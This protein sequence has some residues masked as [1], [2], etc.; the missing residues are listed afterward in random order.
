MEILSVARKCSKYY[1]AL[2]SLGCGCNGI[3]H[4]QSW[5]DVSWL[6]AMIVSGVVVWS[7][8]DVGDGLGCTFI[9]G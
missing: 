8:V 6:A 1:D 9:E 2:C 7:V 5:C 4:L 3:Q